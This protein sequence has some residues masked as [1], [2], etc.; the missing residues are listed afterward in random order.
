MAQVRKHDN[1][2]QMFRFRELICFSLNA[3]PVGLVCGPL[4][5]RELRQC[6]SLDLPH[7]WSAHCRS[8]V[9]PWLLRA[10]PQGGDR[11]SWNTIVPPT[12]LAE[13]CISCLEQW[14]WGRFLAYCHLF[15][16]KKSEL[17]GR[18]E[19]SSWATLVK[20]K[21]ILSGL[22]QGIR[23][24]VCV[25]P[26]IGHIVHWMHYRG[27]VTEG[28]ISFY[29]SSLNAMSIKC[30]LWVLFA[31]VFVMVGV[32][33]PD[34]HLLSSSLD[35]WGVSWSGEVLLWSQAGCTGMHWLVLC[36]LF[37]TLPCWHV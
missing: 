24:V 33:S 29:K 8:D 27:F 14:T 25:L 1:N 5:Q 37:A 17:R 20:G 9:R 23:E 7:H 11:G 16:F 4:P 15:Y 31:V 32:L 12:C 10:S 35:R 21:I 3:A 6:G 30:L 28:I 26:L 34:V 18:T 36:L 13:W 2:R 22:R 19:A